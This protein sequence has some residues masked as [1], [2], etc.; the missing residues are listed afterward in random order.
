M[1]AHPSALSLGLV[2]ALL[3]WQATAGA[4]GPITPGFMPAHA[5]VHG[6]SLVD[7]ASAYTLCAFGTSAE[8][9]P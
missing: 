2:V 1:R 3:L 9:N 7:V 8:V 6:H 4:G 5:R